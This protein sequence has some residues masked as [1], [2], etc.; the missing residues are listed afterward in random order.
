M[1]DISAEDLAA[2]CAH[3]TDERKAEDIL[4]L[5]VGPLTTVTEYF[6]IATGRNVRQLRALGRA[7][8]ERLDEL[9]AEVFGV[10]GEAESGWILIDAGD[11]IV[12]LFA[13]DTRRLYALE[14]LWGSCGE[15]D[16]AA[17]QP[18]MADGRE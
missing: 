4:V 10:E 3:V 7:V 18:L 13:A 15:L 2:T 11:A 8:T 17:R 6:V 16:W 12:H 14:M 9:G 5:H 1:G